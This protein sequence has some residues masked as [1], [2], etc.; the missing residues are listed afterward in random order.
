MALLE[1]KRRNQQEK[2]RNRGG[3]Q[4]GLGSHIAG[5]VVVGIVDLRVDFGKCF[6][7]LEEFDAVDETLLER[8][9]PLE[10]TALHGALRPTE[11]V[12]HQRW[13]DGSVR[14]GRPWRG[15]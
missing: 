5:E 1:R 15:I 3:N 4:P 9:L 7:L 10:E 11:S 8:A 13:S 2:R 6:G 14:L 12:D